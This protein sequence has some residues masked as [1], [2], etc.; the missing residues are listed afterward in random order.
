M[1]YNDKILERYDTSMDDEFE[2]EVLYR[3]IAISYTW[4]TFGVS[5]VS[6]ILAWVLPGLY[7]LLSALPMALIGLTHSIG[8]S[9][10]RERAPVPRVNSSSGEYLLMFLLALAWVSGAIFRSFTVLGLWGLP[11]Y[12][13]MIGFATIGSALTLYS[14]KKRRE[15]DRARLDTQLDED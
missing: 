9:W 10:L 8:E 13:M 5:V 4:L 2:R 14:Y 6:V 3:S 1:S 7:S 12:L 15:D 11:G